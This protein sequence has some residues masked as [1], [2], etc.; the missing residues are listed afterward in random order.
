MQPKLPDSFKQTTDSSDNPISGLI[1]VVEDTPQIQ[2]LLYKQLNAKGYTVVSKDDGM[3]ALK[4]LEENQPD[5]VLLDMMLPEMDGIEVCKNIRKRFKPTELPIIMLSALGMNSDVRVQGLRAGANDFMAKP[6]HKE[7]LYARV[8]SMISQR[9]SV[10]QTESMVSRYVS[11]ALRKQ[12]EIDPEKIQRREERHAVILFADLRGFT[13]M[14][15]QAQTWDVLALLDDFFEAMM[16]V[17]EDHG[18][19]V[20]DISGDQLMAIFNMPYELPVPTHL[21]V[22]TALEMQSLFR[23]LKRRWAQSGMDVGLGIGIHQGNVVAGNV[24]GE[25]LMRYTV[26]GAPVNMAHRLLGLASDGEIIVSTEVFRDAMLPPNVQVETLADVAIKGID[27]P[28]M[29]YKLS[30]TRQTSG[31]GEFKPQPPAA[32]Q[33]PMP[34]APAQPTST[35][36]TPPKTDTPT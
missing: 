5:L 7:E 33:P 30:K 26:I 18:G 4:W 34:V 15:S 3:A 16:A 10:A 1:L 27:T 17:V 20:F 22:S 29:V 13:Q 12:A 28:Q 32:S 35:T 8:A 36:A 31:L 23:F 11:R 21:A 6:W 9:R 24:G 25:K 19:V 2:I 14:S